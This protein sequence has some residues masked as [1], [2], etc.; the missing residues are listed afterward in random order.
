[1]SRVLFLTKRSRALIRNA[2]RCLAG[3]TRCP[4][5]EAHAIRRTS[6]DKWSGVDHSAAVRAYYRRPGRFAHSRDVPAYLGLTPRRHQSGSV[7]H[8]SESARPATNSSALCWFSVL[9]ICWDVLARTVTSNAGALEC[10]NAAGKI[11]FF[12]GPSRPTERLQHQP[13]TENPNVHPAS[14]KAD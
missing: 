7:E 3:K 8:N 9:S 6:P 10:S 2:H 11:V 12:P 1:M 5:R 4:Q 13:D 14:T